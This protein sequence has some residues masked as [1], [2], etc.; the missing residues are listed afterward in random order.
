M[1]LRISFLMDRTMKIIKRSKILVVILI[2]L[3][4]IVAAQPQIKDSTEAYDY[5]AKRGIVEIIYAYMQDYK[6]AKDAKGLDSLEKKGMDSYNSRFID[7]LDVLD[8]DEK[9]DSL[10]DFLQKNDWSACKQYIYQDLKNQYDNNLPLN[11]DFFLVCYRKDTVMPARLIDFIPDI[12]SNDINKREYWK[13][14][15]DKIIKQYNEAL[16]ELGNKGAISQ[17]KSMSQPNPLIDLIIDLLK[18]LAIIIILLICFFLGIKHALRKVK[19]EINDVLSGEINRNNKDELGY[20]ISKEVFDEF[21][22]KDDQIEEFK[23]Y[24]TSN[25][26]LR[27]T[28][29]DKGNTPA[30]YQAEKPESIEQ[31]DYTDTSAQATKNNEHEQITKEWE[32]NQHEDVKL[33]LFY[34]M[35]TTEGAFIAKNKAADGDGVYRIDYYKGH[36]KGELY[37]IE[38]IRDG[39][40]IRTLE[41]RLRPVCNIENVD[42]RDNA[43][44][45]ECLEPGEVVLRNEEWIIDPNNKVKI[46]LL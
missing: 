19:R 12:N 30:E 15:T 18:I 44:K 11:K 38:G 24:K 31:T 33:N 35:P 36:N 22:K 20:A 16:K 8:I 5:W 14:T 34:T 27:A 37:Y 39:K 13:L 3:A 10:P 23:T 28:L 26:E 40:A 41:K 32:I 45:I 6:D 29:V 43:T 4:G 21:Q 9:F 17:N 46:K 1:N 25:S 42:N 2:G 7:S